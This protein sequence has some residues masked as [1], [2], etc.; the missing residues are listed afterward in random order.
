MVSKASLLLCA[1]HVQRHVCL[2]KYG[3]EFGRRG[4]R[5]RLDLLVGPRTA[6]FRCSLRFQVTWMRGRPNTSVTFNGTKASFTVDS[7][8]QITAVVPAGA[9]PVPIAVTTPAGTA[10]ERH[11]F[12]LA[13][14]G[15]G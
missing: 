6:R 4:Q 8:T 10:T 7:P 11:Q 13:V 3:T 15:A 12:H 9:T 1:W 14:R 2:S 5:E